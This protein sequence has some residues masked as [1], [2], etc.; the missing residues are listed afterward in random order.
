LATAG[1]TPNP[2]TGIAALT[3]IIRGIR[4]RTDFPAEMLF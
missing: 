4:P 2:E 3:D 1:L